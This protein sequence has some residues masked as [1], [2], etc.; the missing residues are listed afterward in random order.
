[1][2]DFVELTEGNKARTRTAKDYSYNL[3]HMWV[4][5]SFSSRRIQCSWPPLHF[6]LVHRASGGANNK[7]YFHDDPYYPLYN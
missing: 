1:M 5:C 3:K 7:T 6:E 4:I 2:G